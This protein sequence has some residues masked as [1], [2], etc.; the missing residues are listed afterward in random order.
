MTRFDHVEYLCGPRGCGKEELLRAVVYIG[1]GRGCVSFMNVGSKE[2][3]GVPIWEARQWTDIASSDAL[4]AGRPRARCREE[5]AQPQKLDVLTLDIDFKP[6]PVAVERDGD[7][8]IIKDRASGEVVKRASESRLE[9]AVKEAAARFGIQ[10]ADVY[11][12][13]Y[14]GEGEYPSL[15][16]ILR[17]ARRVHKKLA[18]VGADAL[19]LYSGAKGFHVKLV[20]P[21]L[22]DAAF[23]PRLARGLAEFLG[24]SDADPHAFDINRKLRVPYT[25]N[26]KTGGLALIFDP[27]TG[28]EI[29]ELRWPRPVDPSVIGFLIQPRPAA[30]MAEGQPRQG[31]WRPWVPLLEQVTAMNPKLK[32][33]CRKRFSALFGCACAHDGLDDAA[34][35]ERL[36]AALGMQSLGAYAAAMKSGFKACAARIASG[37]KPLYSIR[38][39]LSV[40]A[41]EESGVW[42]GIKECIA[43]MPPLRRPPGGRAAEESRPEGS[44]HGGAPSAEP[45]AEAEEPAAAEEEAAES[46]EEELERFIREH[47]PGP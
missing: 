46:A 27:A 44:R 10:P 20:M 37:Q 35:A 32:E 16:Y 17:R 9:R 38:R 8:Y 40:S 11:D 24:I 26:S 23:R 33:D 30:Q 13:V 36:A 2:W 31:V 39:A 29:K 15:E 18:G 34:C 14:W 1:E 3:F 42:Y 6:P 21:K 25:V 45:P 12:A 47:L 41:G 4:Y 5:G 19:F 43:Q 7:R 22:Y 28:E